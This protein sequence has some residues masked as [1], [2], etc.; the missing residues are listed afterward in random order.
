[1]TDGK[2]SRQI[3]QA[4]RTV[5]EANPVVREFLFELLFM[6]AEREGQWRWKDTYRGKIREYTPRKDTDNENP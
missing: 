4:V 1:M 2:I 6:E 5:A 3:L